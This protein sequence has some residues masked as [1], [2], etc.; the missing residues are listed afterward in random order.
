MATSGST[1]FKLQ[2]SAIVQASLRVLGVL[3]EGET[4]S[5]AQTSICAEGFN[6]FIKSLQN[7]GINLWVRTWVQE[8]LTATSVVSNGGSVYSCVKNHTSSAS[9]EP[10]VSTGW[11]TYWE[12]TNGTAT[13]AWSS[14]SVS[15]NYIGEIDLSSGYIGVESAFI[16]E[17]NGTNNSDYELDILPFESYFK[18]LD[19][20]ITPGIPSELFTRKR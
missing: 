16:R 3:G 17:Y 20:N 10:G 5:T 6:V 19:K 2:R 7:K 4:P 18:I 15:Y 13:G 1:D 8:S 12:K 11:T 14:S 9:I